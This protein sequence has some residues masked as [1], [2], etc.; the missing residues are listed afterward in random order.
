MR[1]SICLS[2]CLSVRLSIYISIYP[3]I[4]VYLSIYGSTALLDLGRF[5]S[6]LMYSQSIGHLE[7]GI[8]LSQ[9]RYLHTEQQKQRINAHRHP[10]LV[11]FEPTIAVL[12][13]AKTVHGF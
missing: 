8:S 4:Y 12:E 6:F 9:G 1:S 11:G 13:R 10:C 7:R 3:S 2:L 5:I